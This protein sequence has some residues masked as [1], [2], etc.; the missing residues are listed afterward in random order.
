LRAKF[1]TEGSE[2]NQLGAAA[3]KGA[4]EYLCVFLSDILLPVG[5][6]Y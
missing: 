6:K 3:S 2:H 5:N 1:E 4:L